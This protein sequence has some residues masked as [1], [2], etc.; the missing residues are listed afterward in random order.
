M[1]PKGSGEECGRKPE[2]QHNKTGLLQSY[3]E[4]GTLVEVFAFPKLYIAAR[5]PLQSEKRSFGTA[6]LTA[7][8]RE[9]RL[10]A[11]APEGSLTV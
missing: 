5:I 3:H 10:G 11:A 6:F 7:S 2:S 8:P 1:A 4:V 9:K